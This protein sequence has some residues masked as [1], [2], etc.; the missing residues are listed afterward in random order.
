MTFKGNQKEVHIAIAEY[1][2]S[3]LKS[4]LK[5]LNEVKNS[6]QYNDSIEIIES[7]IT[8]DELNLEKLKTSNTSD[9]SNDYTLGDIVEMS[10]ALD[11][12]YNIV[13]H[14][15]NTPDTPQKVKDGLGSIES[16]A[17]YKFDS[18]GH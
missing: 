2:I 12:I 5:K 9:S 6:C 1:Q 15:M 18:V 7:S 14:I 10:T 13:E 16:I 8:T 17:R 3:I 4:N 11:A